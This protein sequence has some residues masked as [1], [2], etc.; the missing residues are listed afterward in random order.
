[1]LP[2]AERNSVGG[3]VSDLRCASEEA[4]GRHATSLAGPCADTTVRKRLISASSR[5]GG[6][7]SPALMGVRPY[8]GRG[9]LEGR[10]KTWRR[11]RGREW[12]ARCSGLREA[13]LPRK[14]ADPA[15]RE[16]S[17]PAPRPPP[18][19]IR[20]DHRCRRQ[21]CTPARRRGSGAPIHHG[22]RMRMP[23]PWL[24]QGRQEGGSWMRTGIGTWE[25]REGKRRGHRVKS[26]HFRIG[27][28][29]GVARWASHLVRARRGASRMVR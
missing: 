4:A 12:P 13:C 17:C 10:G 24:R 19:C 6:A 26:V 9:F 29:I 5:A 7:W 28:G 14:W 23:L 21:A 20:N 25:M 18:S 27:T 15:R 8:R 11:A 3:R 2:W 16:G 1:M 22:G